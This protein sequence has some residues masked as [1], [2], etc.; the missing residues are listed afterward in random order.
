MNYYWKLSS[1][2]QRVTLFIC[3]EET[4]T[5]TRDE[6]INKL[7]ILKRRR[8]STKKAKREVVQCFKDALELLR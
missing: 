4:E 1:D 7:E 8:Y 5:Y 6:L 3:N 2:A